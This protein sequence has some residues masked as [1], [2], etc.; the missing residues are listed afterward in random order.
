MSFMCCSRYSRARGSSKLTTLLPRIRAS[1]NAP[2][3][4]AEPTASAV[5]MELQLS[6]CPVSVPAEPLPAAEFLSSCDNLDGVCGELPNLYR[7]L[8]VLRT[9][10]VPSSSIVVPLCHVPPAGPVAVQLRVRMNAVAAFVGPL[11]LLLV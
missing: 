1:V 10:A 3:R 4:R 11:P 5:F 2:L 9:S 7:G 6:W 8:P